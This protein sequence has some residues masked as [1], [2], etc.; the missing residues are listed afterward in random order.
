MTNEERIRTEIYELQTMLRRIA[1]TEGWEPILNPDGLFGKETDA[2][3]RTFQKSRLLPVT[4]VV[5][6]A[7]WNAVYDAY[8]YALYITAPSAAIFPFPDSEYKTEAGEKS[9]IVYIIQIILAALAIAYDQFEPMMP[10]GVYDEKTASLVMQFQKAN[11]LTQTGIVDR[12][13]WDAMAQNYNEFA[14][15]RYYSH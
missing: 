14:N 13:T 10:T 5:D 15:N 12:E 6:L 9:D 1:Q 7:T 4:G 3:V 2:A 8:Q 11:L